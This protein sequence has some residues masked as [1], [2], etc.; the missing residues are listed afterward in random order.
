MDKNKDE[1]VLIIKSTIEA[2]S[3]YSDEKMNKIIEDPTAMIP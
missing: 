3:Q 2:R 1:Q